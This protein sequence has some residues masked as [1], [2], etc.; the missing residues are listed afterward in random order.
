MLIPYHFP[1]GTPR[2][3]WR[4]CAARFLKHLPYLWPKSATFPT[5]FMTRPKIRYPIYDRC[6]WHS[7]PKHNFWR[8]FVYG[9]IEKDEKVASSKKHTQ[10]KTRE[11]IPYP[12]W[13]QNG[14]ISDTLFMT[15]TAEKP[16]PLGPHIPTTTSPYKGVTPGPFL[17]AAIKNPKLSTTP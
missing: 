3:I 8:A 1:R 13:D 2:K 4:G 6:G 16:Y 14:Q 7:C 17:N 9:L 11:Q 10:F 5:L 12:I 15:K